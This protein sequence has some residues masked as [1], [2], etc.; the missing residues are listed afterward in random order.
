MEFDLETLQT[1]QV[2]AYLIVAGFCVFMLYGYIH[3]LYSSEKKGTRD[4]EKYRDIALDD[5]VDSTPLEKLSA[6]EKKKLK[7][8]KA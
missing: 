6:W 5:N 7:G 3:Y 4:W 1:I 2:Y 8:D